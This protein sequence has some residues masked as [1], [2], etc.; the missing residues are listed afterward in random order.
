M[1]SLGETADIGVVLVLLSC[2]LECPNAMEE[3]AMVSDP[4]VYCNR[5]Y[6]LAPFIS[7]SKMAFLSCFLYST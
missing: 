2:L 5:P 4:F 6:L 1:L 3:N 7:I